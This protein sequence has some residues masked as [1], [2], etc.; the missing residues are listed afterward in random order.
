MP[1]ILSMAEA[2][3]RL[4]QLHDEL[5]QDAHSEAAIITDNGKPALAILPWELYDGMLETIEM[6]GDPEQMAALR[7]GM[8]DI[9][10]GRTESWEVVKAWLRIPTAP[11][12]QA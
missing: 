11:E 1:R 4:E 5:T 8:Q 12:Q 6:L 9:A 10:D 3:K 7:E 2:L